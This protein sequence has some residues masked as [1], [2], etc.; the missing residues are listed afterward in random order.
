M[1]EIYI[2]TSGWLYKSWQKRFYPASL[3]NHE[4][5]NFY[6]EEF[7]TVEINS[8]FYHL[9]NPNSYS[10]WRKQVPDDFI[11]SVKASRYLTHN[12]KLKDPNEPWRRMLSGAHRLKSK[13]GPILLQFPAHWKKNYDR[14]SEFLDSVTSK[15]VNTPAL[16]FEFRNES[17][18]CKEV[19]KLLEKYSAA[20]CIADSHSFPRL[21]VSTA[22]FA[23][24]RFHGR[25][26]IDP[27]YTRTQL[28]KEAAIMNQFKNDGIGV[29]AYFN[30]DAK[31]YAIE[32]AQTLKSLVN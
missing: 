22:D 25:Q 28:K 8:T 2:G 17:W 23:Y 32:N 7:A 26:K 24:F 6:A 16:V 5:L 21:T 4:C 27:K 18:L 1:A 31:G 9:A 12:K 11:F 20:W 14:L 13:L 19:L 15:Q 3:P 30:N 10:N 29:F